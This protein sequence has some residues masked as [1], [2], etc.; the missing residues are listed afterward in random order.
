MSKNQVFEKTTENAPK[1]RG[2]RGVYPAYKPSGVAWLGDIPAHWEVKRLKQILART[3]GGVWGDDYYDDGA[4]VLRS[5]DMTVTGEWRI[6][7]PARRKLT[8]SEFQYARLQAGDL[9]IT[10]S[11]GSELHLGKTA[12]VTPEVEAQNCCFSNFM[13]RLRVK[14]N[15][16]SN[17]FY[18]LLN[19]PIAREQ[20]N[21]FG[22]T[23]T[24]LAN[25]NGNLIGNLI[26]PFPPLFEQLAIAAYLDRETVRID[27]LVAKNQR[28]I[29][30]LL[31]KRTALISHTVTRGLDANA[32]L[33]DSGVAW[34]GKI[35]THWEVVRSKRLFSL[36]NVKAISSDKQLTVSQEHGVIAQDEFMTREGR[37]VVQVVTGVDILKHVEPNDFVISMR[38]FQG[39]IEWSRIGGATSSAYVVLIPSDQVDPPYFS[40]LLKCKWYIQALQSTSNLVRDGQALRFANF[41]LVD[42]PALPL[43][44]QRAIAA[45]LNREIVKIDALVGKVRQV[46]EKLQEYRT[47]LVSAAV[48][49]KIQIPRQDAETP[50]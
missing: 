21:Y 17:Y 30:L 34:L 5:T 38:S 29:E 20:F 50:N 39:G 45:Y 25:L 18:R 19:S 14:H 6:D 27:A 40:Y 26:V 28:L 12:M 22:S 8:A 23:T 31:E 49:G 48:T 7:N 15:S 43:P 44:E 35:P 37:R 46:I 11:S 1:M 13:L 9:L 10:K 41:S 3:D 36:R 2:P 4:I 32:P 47:A 42:L 24:G 33:K 16:H